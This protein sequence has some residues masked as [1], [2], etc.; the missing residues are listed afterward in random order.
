MSPKEYAILHEQVED[1]IKKGLVRES[2]S[3]VAVPTS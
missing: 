1:L 2:M 3:P